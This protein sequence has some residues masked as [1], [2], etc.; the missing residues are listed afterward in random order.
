MRTL[1]DLQLS[2]Y[3]SLAPLPVIGLSS[4]ILGHH[5]DELARQ[6]RMLCLA[7]SQIGAGFVRLL[8]LLDVLLDALQLCTHPVGSFLDVGH[9]ILQLLFRL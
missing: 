1:T 6:R 3:S 4:I 5:F 2:L 7:Y 9:Q 8:L